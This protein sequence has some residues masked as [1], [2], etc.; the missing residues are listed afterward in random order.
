MSQEATSGSPLPFESASELREVHGRLLE[1]LDAALG[2]DGSIAGE[3]DALARI[4]PQ[5][6]EFLDRGSATGA[7]LEETKERTAC[8]VL[9]DYWGASLSRAAIAPVGARL[10]PFDGERL[11]DLRDKPCPYVGLEAFRDRDFFF[12]REDDT[13]KLQAQLHDTP[14]VVVVGASGSGKS[15][16]VMGGLL[17]ALRDERAELRVVGPFVPG[18]AV[19]HNLAGAVS[20]AVARARGGV[21]AAPASFRQDPQHLSAWLGGAKAPPVLI[22]IDQFEEVFTL[23]DPADREALVSNI[24]RL[25]E[26]DPRHRVLLTMREEFKSRMVLLRA[27][28]AYLDRA[29]FSMRPL[30]YEELRA[31]VEKPAALVNLQFRSGIADDLVKKV[32]GQP[33][34]LPLLQFTLRALWERRDR[35]RITWEVYRKVGDPMNALRDS[36]DEFYDRLAPETQ[37]E[38]R[39]ILLELVRV[40]ELLEAYRQPVPLSHLLRA[41]RANT[42]QVIDL[43]AANDYVRVTTAARDADAVVEVKHESLVR[44]W[45][46]FVTWI[47]EKRHERRQRLALTQAAERWALKGRPSEGL[48]TGWQLE[49]AK[50]QPDLSRLEEE[51]VRASAEAFERTQRERV[52]ALHAELRRSRRR[53]VVTLVLAILYVGVSVLTARYLWNRNNNLQRLAQ[54]LDADHR[55]LKKRYEELQAAKSTQFAQQ[56]GKTF[57]AGSGA[58]TGQPVTIY[59]HISSDEQRPRAKEVAGLLRENRIEVPKIQKVDPVSRSNVRFF[60]KE[61][62]RGAEEISRLLNEYL[63]GQASV[64]PT[65]IPGYEEKVPRRRYEIWFAPDALRTPLEQRAAAVPSPPATLPTDSGITA[66]NDELYKQQWSFFENGSS[67]PRSP[68]GIGLSRAWAVTKGSPSI[69]VGLVSTGLVADHVDITGSGNVVPGYDMISAPV[70]AGDGDGRDADATDPGSCGA[71]AEKTTSSWSGTHAAGIVGAVR[72]NNGIGIAGANWAVRVQP[73]RAISDCGGSVSDV[74]DGIRWAA[75]L[76]VVGVPANATPAR[77]ILIGA[78]M[79][80]RCSTLPT[81]QKAINDAVAVGATVIAAAGNNASDAAESAPG[82]CENVITVAAS[83]ARGR[84]VARYSNFGPR[85]DILAPG[86][87]L[88]RDDNGDGLPDGILSTVKGGYATYNGTTMAAA[89]VAAV[90]ALL[91]AKEPDRTPAEVRERLKRSALPRSKEECPR[92]CGAGLLNAELWN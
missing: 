71:G 29:W 28:G 36:A 32:L 70:V 55:D 7:F 56:L 59:L 4:E 46:R 45:P 58:P 8:Q 65:L 17:P 51:F 90:A 92:P 21:E 63:G 20:G 69:V 6:R 24:V 13:R 67:G 22:V 66:P 3:A 42:G 43:L 74:V 78:G 47:D 50:D 27:L 75:G 16:L 1:S 61:D 38:V 73:I 79:P 2:E 31:A 44:N 86:G 39:R 68:G 49:E 77:V 35:N 5:V 37:D 91:L 76:A 41:G 72:T 89:H 84:L 10:A 15:S 14:L 53:L 87:D 85:V 19:L 48:L 9:L 52:D 88:Q 26:A 25:L 83:D 54:S 62:A 34:A 80:V 11:P 82:G 18:I 12:G 33:T 30:G 40:D 57:E 60:H 81:M 23:S 64:K